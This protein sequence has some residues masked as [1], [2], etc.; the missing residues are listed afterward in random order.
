D[1]FTV[2]GSTQ[3]DPCFIAGIWT[4]PG[5]S[6]TQGGHQILNNIIQSN[7]AGIELDNVGTFP[8]KVQFNLIQNNNNPGPNGGTGIEVN[9]GLTNALIDSNKF[10][11]HTN[12]AFELF[13]ASNVTIVNNEFALNR[14][15]LGMGGVTTATVTSNNIHNST[16]SA[17]ADIRMFGAVTDLQI[18][19]NDLTD[20]AG[21]GIRMDDQCPGCPNSNVTINTN[22]ISGYAV[23]GLEV[24]SGA[25]L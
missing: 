13:S 18:T 17:T 22:N 7:V 24:D 23:A 10:V 21:R 5:Y 6:G 1:G 20:G 11:G 15:A 25:Y 4:N 16:D 8:T 3:S 19:C 14:R 2:Q 9:F 12:S